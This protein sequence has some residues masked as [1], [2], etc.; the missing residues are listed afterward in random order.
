MA[1]LVSVLVFLGPC[2]A[3]S[4]GCGPSV[5]SIYEGNV[6]FEHC[7]RLDIDPHIAPTHREA[8]WKEWKETYTYGQT[9]DRVEYAQRRIRALASGDF[10]RPVLE[11]T[12]DKLLARPPVAPS[13]APIPTSLHAPPPPTA[14]APGTSDAGPP[15]ASLEDDDEPPERPDGECSNSCDDAWDSCADSCSPPAGSKDDGKAT[16]LDKKARKA[17]AARKKQ[18]KTCRADYRKC[19]RRCFK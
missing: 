13:E 11:A 16:H 18:C 1:R 5:Q 10:R 6:R 19:M 9:R 3:L 7:Y 12:P 8:C 4:A 14:P 15:D 17:E 2:A